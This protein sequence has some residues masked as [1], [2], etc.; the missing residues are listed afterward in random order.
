MLL[1]KDDL[2][3]LNLQSIYY[4]QS[5]QS[6]NPNRL[7]TLQEYHYLKDTYLKNIKSNTT[8]KSPTIINTNKKTH[9]SSLYSLSTLSRL[10]KGSLIIKYSK[11]IKNSIFSKRNSNIVIFNHQIKKVKRINLKNISD[12]KSILKQLE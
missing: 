12:A 5:T 1:V 7:I 2:K 9:S 3:R 6:I 11:K 10:T 8:R 4:H